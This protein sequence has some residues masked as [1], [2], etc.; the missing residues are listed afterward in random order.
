VPS[1]TITITRPPALL[2]SGGL[3]FVFPEEFV[4]KTMMPAL[5]L[6]LLSL[7]ARADEAAIPPP[8]ADVSP[9][10]MIVVVLLLVAMVG[11][12]IAFTVLKD[13]KRN[14]K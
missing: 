1:A 2:P 13:R 6:F 8:P 4:M 3:T 14:G 11:G 12:F 7:S 10:A 9:V 5:G